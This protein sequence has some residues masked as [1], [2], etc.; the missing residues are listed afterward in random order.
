MSGYYYNYTKK[1]Y[2]V[3]KIIVTGGCG[4]I[5]SHTSCSL[6]NNNMLPIIVDN[7]DNSYPWIIDN[8]KNRYYNYTTKFYPVGCNEIES[9]KE[10]DRI[11]GIIHFAAL[12]SVGESVK[13]PMLYYQNNIGSLLNILEIIEKYRIQ[14]F[15]F[16]SSCTVYGDAKPPV[17]EDAPIQ[18]AFCPY[19]ETKIMGE[20]IIRSF[21]NKNKDLNCTILRYFNPIG[22]SEKV[23]IGENAKRTP[24]NLLSRLM[25][26][27][28]GKDSF[29]IHGTDYNTKDGSAIRDY[30][31]VN[32]L[33]DCHVECLKNMMQKKGVFDV[34]NV[35]TGKG[36]SVFEIVDTFKEVTGLKFDVKVGERRVGDIESIY[37]DASKIKRELDFSCDTPLE[38]SLKQAWKWQQYLNSRI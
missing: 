10:I 23:Q 17:N 6:I 34:Y 36:V 16:S 32:D 15:V 14:N 37:A 19:G 28:S 24:E 5:G 18:D 11:D 2:A 26:Y 9:V 27:V 8:I 35:G 7:N 29:V 4:Y 22:A 31:N 1:E 25:R 21:Y 33:G 13:N 30:L 12:K 3:K 38:V 20:K